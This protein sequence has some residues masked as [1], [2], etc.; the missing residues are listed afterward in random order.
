MRYL[1]GPVPVSDE[2]WHHGIKGQKWGVQNGPPYPLSEQQKVRYKG[3]KEDDPHKTKG[4]KGEAVFY[5]TRALLH[6]VT[7]NPIGLVD[8][9]VRGSKAVAGEIRAKQYERERLFGEIEDRTGFRLK[10]T[11]MSEEE[12]LK[13]VNPQINN[14][15]S[16]TKSNCMLCTVT[17]ELRRR[18]YDVTAKKASIGY[19]LEY[20]KKWFPSL[21]AEAMPEKRTDFKTNREFGRKAV[22]WMLKQP[23]GSRGNLSVLFLGSGGHSMHYEIKNGQLIIRDG[24][25]NRTYR[26]P[27]KILSRAFVVGC[28]RLDNLAFDPEAIKECCT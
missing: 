28:A 27:E 16:N 5:A 24:Q 7:L 10:R 20:A 23:E 15:N 2:L 17:Y 6:L 11:E 21:K 14:F 9:I 3:T 12:D 1:V 19:T 18:G 22:E 13:R 4:D 26:N 8:D 25:I